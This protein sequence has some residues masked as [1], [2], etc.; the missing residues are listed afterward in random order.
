MHQLINPR[1]YGFRESWGTSTMIVI[2]YKEIK[3][4]LVNKKRTNIVLRDVAKS[5][6]KV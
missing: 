2:A 5:F 1:Q 3:L 6:N 4:A